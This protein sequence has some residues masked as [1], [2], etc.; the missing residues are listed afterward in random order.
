MA[1]S[2]FHPVT[3]IVHIKQ[4]NRVRQLEFVPPM[5]VLVSKKKL[6][7]QFKLCR[8]TE[9]NNK[10]NLSHTCL[11]WYMYV[12]KKMALSYLI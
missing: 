8:K 6:L 12:R 4:K 11:Y 1:W 3:Y 2:V 10:E 5:Y 9:Y 7:I